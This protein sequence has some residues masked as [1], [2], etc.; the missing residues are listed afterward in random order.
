MR[1]RARN[2]VP[3]GLRFPARL[4]LVTFE[5]L[6]AIL[7]SNPIVSSNST[8][9]AFCQMHSVVQRITIT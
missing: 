7:T 2:F 9:V 5:P 4:R 1:G 8:D 3:A 6:I